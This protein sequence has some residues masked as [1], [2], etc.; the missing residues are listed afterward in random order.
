MATTATTDVTAWIP[1]LIST[2]VYDTT[3]APLNPLSVWAENYGELEGKAGSSATIP[4]LSPTTPADNLAETVAA[5]DDKIAGAGVTVTIKEAVKSIA[6]TDR[7]KVQSGPNVNQIAG[8]RVGQAINDRIELDLGAAAVAGRTIASDTAAATLTPTVFRTMRSKIAP[9][10]RRRGVTL[11]APAAALDGLYSD[12]TFQS[13]A[14]WGG[15]EGLREGAVARYQGIDIQE[16]DDLTLPVITALK[17][18][19]MMMTKGALI[20]AVQ[21]G[22][23]VETERDARGRITRIVGTVFHGEGVV[24]ARGMVAGIIG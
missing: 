14:T 4:T 10:L 1:A 23:Q 13:A 20:R 7:V 12:A 19:V 8:Q 18:T 2:A 21:R 22:P 9:G 15:T 24:D 3:I 5:V 17:T 16:I 11:F 6:F